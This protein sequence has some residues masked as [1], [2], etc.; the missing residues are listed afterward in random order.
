MTCQELLPQLARLAALELDEAGETAARAHLATCPSCR[1]ALVELE[2]T[3]QLVFPLAAAGRVEE[4]EVFVQGVLSGVHHRRVER[5]LGKPHW[6]LAAAASVAGVV[7]G[8]YAGL[9]LAGVG[10]GSPTGASSVA[11][12]PS[13]APLEQPPFVEVNGKN[14]RVYHLATDP[15]SEIRV[16]VVVNPALEL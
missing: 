7:L 2:P 14:L 13:P 1:A 3:Y 12:R 10:A 16:A 15:E 4:D 5:R 6:R 8:G 11:A 9:K